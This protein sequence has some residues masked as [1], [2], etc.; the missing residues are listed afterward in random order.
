MDERV[1]I[2]LVYSSSCVIAV[3][4]CVNNFEEGEVYETV[5]IICPGAGF[6]FLFR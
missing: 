2:I 5:S 1:D 4:Y 3:D 6:S